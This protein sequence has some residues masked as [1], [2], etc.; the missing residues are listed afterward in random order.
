MNRPELLAPAGNPATALAA[1]DAGADAIYAGLAKFNARERGENFTPESL[2]KIITYA[3]KLGR[4]VY[5]TVNTVIKESELPELMLMLAEVSRLGPDALIVQDPGVVRLVR[6]YFPELKLHASTQMGFHNSAGLEVAA[7]LGFSRVILERQLTLEELAEIRKKT[8]LELEVFVHGA[9][10][11]SLS[12]QCLFSSFLGGASGNRGK[13]KQPCRRRYFSRDGNGFFFSPQDLCAIDL[14]PQLMELGIASFKIEGRLRQPD[15]V[16]QVVKS[17]RRMIDAAQPGDRAFQ[18][19]LRRELSKACGRKWSHGFFSAE[20]MRDLIQHQAMGASGVLSG[21]VDE[22]REN[23]FGFTA[24]KRLHL[25]DRIRL[26]ETN[27]EEG[28]ALTITRMFVDNQS[29][30]RVA[31]GHRVF[32]CCDKPVREHSLVFKIGESFP[33]YSAR[34]AALPAPRQGLNFE[35]T[36]SRSE[37][38]IRVLQTAL[39]VWTHP[40]ALAPAAKH[41]VT[42]DTLAREFAAGDSTQ[43]EVKKID[44]TLDGNYFF[45]APEL[46]AVR[47]E[48]WSWLKER[49]TPEAVSDPAGRALLDFRRDYLAQR[50]APVPERTVETVAVV[51]GGAQPANRQ[52]LLATGIFELNK[53]CSEAILPEFCPEERLPTLSRAVERA[54]A[55]GIR[56]FRLTG[57]YGFAFFRHHPEA[58]LIVSAPVP[59]ANSQC[60]EQLRELGAARCLAHLEL[61]RDALLALRDHAT[62]PLELYRLGRPPL[63]V[64]RA[65]LPVT[66]EIRDNRGRKFLIRPNA[67]EQ[68]TRLYPH[69]VMSIPRLPGMYDFYDLTCANWN[70]RE[71]TTFNFEGGLL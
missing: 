5:L 55:Q 9:L 56:R 45:P 23:G 19:E 25:G 20:A 53:H 51:P 49:L 69:E 10:C 1:F 62:L 57:L 11:C 2:G 14:V 18:G 26:Q 70:P 47:R 35:L 42:A 29:A 37:L 36:L 16:S 59:V 48:F 8:N 38:R 71:T 13:C 41:P 63:L 67:R 44:C 34:L 21:Q 60:V 52:A 65:R 27:S 6:R 33:D 43:F 54:W 12:G 66:G 7:R 22:V 40:L 30:T 17:Y 4:R 31:P 39:P 61:E 64:T 28:A 46:K 50:P 24:R 15:Y 58:E 3:H 68:L 32:I